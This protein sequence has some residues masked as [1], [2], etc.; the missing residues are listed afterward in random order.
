[1]HFRPRTILGQ[2]FPFQ[3]AAV[4][5]NG[6]HKLDIIVADNQYSRIFVLTNNGTG[7]FTV[8]PYI[9]AQA[10]LISFA[11]VDANNDGAPD[12]MVGTYATNLLQVLTNNG[13]GVFSA[14]EE[15]QDSQPATFLASADVNQ[16]NRLDV[17]AAHYNFTASVFTNALFFPA[18]MLR[19]RATSTNSAILNWPLY[20]TNY[21]LQQNTNLATTNWVTISNSVDILTGTNQVVLP[22][23]PGSRFYR[24]V[25]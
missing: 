13:A 7:Q 18:P 1:L 15:I 25:K 16:D 14:A 4:D 3:A 9:Q 24:L 6:D 23:Q 2:V 22:R 19:I 8:E 21:L 11:V 20:G 17:I 5:V 12:I 10:G